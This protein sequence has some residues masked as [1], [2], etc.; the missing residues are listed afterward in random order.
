MFPGLGQY[1][2]ELRRQRRLEAIVVNQMVSPASSFA[3]RQQNLIK[4]SQP[5][6]TPQNNLPKFDWSTVKGRRFMGPRI[7]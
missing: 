5:R 4:R 7:S 1:G 2:D 6:Y 3:R